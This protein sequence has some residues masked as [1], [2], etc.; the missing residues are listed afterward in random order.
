MGV[1]ELT[2]LVQSSKELTD[3]L[4]ELRGK[5][6]GW[7]I[8]VLMHKVLGSRDGADQLHAAPCVPITAAKS[9]V[10]DEVAKF[11]AFVIRLVAYTDGASH[12]KKL[13]TR[14]READAVKIEK[15]LKAKFNAGY[16]SDFNEVQ[17][18]KKK[19]GRVPAHM[20]ALVV[21][22]LK[23]EHGIDSVGAPFEAEWQLAADERD[24]KIAAVYSTDSDTFPLGCRTVINKLKWHT[25]EQTDDDGNVLSKTRVVRCSIL[26]R[27]E[28]L[29]RLKEKLE[30]SEEL[31]NDAVLALCCFLGNDYI[32]RVKGTG[33]SAAARFT[34]EWLSA[35]SAKD[36]AS[37]LDN[38]NSKG[39]YHKRQ[40]TQGAGSV[41]GYGRLFGQA[42]S[43]YK[44]CPV[45]RKVARRVELQPLCELPGDKTWSE[46]I[47]FDPVVLYTKAG[48]A[49]G[50]AHRMIESC[51]YGPGK[52]K[53]LPKPS[54]PHD[55]SKDVEH[56]A[57]RDFGEVPPELTP[58]KQL[59]EWLYWRNIPMVASSSHFDLASAARRALD[60][61]T[62]GSPRE[63][64]DG[65]GPGGTHWVSWE[66]IESRDGGALDWSE[67][68][69]V[70]EF[71]R[72]GQEV[73][74]QYIDE[75]FGVGRNGVRRRAAL[76]YISGHYDATSW[77]M[78]DAKLIDN[79]QL[80]KVVELTC[81]PSMKSEGYCIRLVYS[82]GGDLL[83][84]PSQCSCPDG[85]F[86]CSH[87]LGVLLII[88]TVQ[89]QNGWSIDDLAGS[90]PEPIK[91]IQSLPLSV[92]F[93]HGVVGKSELAL[94]KELKKMGKELA[95][96]MPGY[97][98]GGDGEI[99]DH[100]VEA[101][102]RAEGASDKK[103]IDICKEVDDV[104]ELSKI[105]A[106][107]RG[108]S[109]PAVSTYSSAAIHEFN[110]K[111]VAGED[112]SSEEKKRRK[113]R[114][115]ER[116]EALYRIQRLGGVPP[117]LLSNYVSFGPFRTERMRI[118]KAAKSR[119]A[120]ITDDE[121]R[122]RFCIPEQQMEE[123]GWGGAPDPLF[124]HV[125]STSNAT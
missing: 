50:D 101:Q 13:V 30:F 111:R 107:A 122:E 49:M 90:M 57:V 60:E 61:E 56:G 37:V 117:S 80:V 39:R 22:Y 71:Y 68:K 1:L 29:G 94:S 124:G 24:G 47:G 96:E 93:V 102:S 34:K 59:I 43:L 9:F 7:D 106:E 110:R 31:S 26:R 75:N 76:R 14:K 27:D 36:K 12:P 100:V 115:A 104:V 95:A 55:S 44:Y 114:K 3:D 4:E 65:A 78:A 120:T 119:W 77:R 48:V 85:A 41:Y 23:T 8:S 74:P 83:R 46:L 28:V 67:P 54:H 45:F 53:P 99:A 81:T 86:F 15:K 64:R 98:T 5:T 92:S 113:V 10:D 91:T 89:Q 18:L 123:G 118:L 17:K 21:D 109:A 42:F 121:I 73:D 72:S 108:S 52:M 70:L 105:R 97:S 66:Q 103:S 16:I 87:M 20:L 84:N 35:K 112:L 19:C 11:A 40:W 58:D 33:K 79:G 88:R 6:V 116:H 38:M 32:F 82:E 69:S 51:R 2:E 25:E 62:A 125:I 63:I